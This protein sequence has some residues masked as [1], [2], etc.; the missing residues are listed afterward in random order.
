MACWLVTG[1]HR[2][3]D[4]MIQHGDSAGRCAEAG[5]VLTGCPW[6]SLSRPA[7]HSCRGCN[8]SCKTSRKFLE[9]CVQTKQYLDIE[10]SVSHLTLGERAPGP[11]RGLL[12]L[13]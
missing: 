4:E 5:G 11:V 13:I 9:V 6:H 8:A 10:G 7:R 1:H 3:T 2:C 12:S